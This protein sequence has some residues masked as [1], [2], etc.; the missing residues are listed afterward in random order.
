MEI[1]NSQREF[2]DMIKDFQEQKKLF[3]EQMK[4]VK[5]LLSALSDG[6]ELNFD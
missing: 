2:E 3:D 1:E 5:S 4:K 6:V